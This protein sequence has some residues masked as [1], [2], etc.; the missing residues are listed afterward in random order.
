M[1]I[2]I[3]ATDQS[4]GG[5]PAWLFILPFGIMFGLVGSLIIMQ[6]VARRHLARAAQF[7]GS[8]V[9]GTAQLSWATRAGRGWATAWGS[10]RGQVGCRIGLRVSIPGR[11][12]YD[13]TVTAIV[14]SGWAYNAIRWP[15]GGTYVVQVDSA[16]P[17]KVRF[18]YKQKYQPGG[19]QVDRVGEAVGQQMA[20]PPSPFGTGSQVATPLPALGPPQR[21]RGVGMV[22][23]PLAAVLLLLA[24]GLAAAIMSGRH[25]GSTSS[26]T[27]SSSSQPS[28]QAMPNAAPAP[29]AV[30]P[31][32]VTYSV[33]GT[34]GPGDNITVT[35]TDPSGRSHFQR[36]ISIPW[37][38]TLVPISQSDAVSVQAISSNGTSQLNCSITASDGTIL[39]QRS[40]NSPAATC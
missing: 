35:F 33:T 6:V 18:D 3:L 9:T 8:A 10:G 4:P 7:E 40:D 12:P 28:S 25:T 1:E 31:R 15:D 23:L 37:V 30:G 38:L 21:R 27:Q 14:G 22:L 16:N 36:N 34:K 32:Q 13:V 24:V 11:A 2:V 39:S 19:V 29:S 17:E 20:P 5:P 26:A